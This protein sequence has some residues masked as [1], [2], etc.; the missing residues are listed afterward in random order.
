MFRAGT[1][2]ETLMPLSISVTI[3]IAVFDFRSHCKFNVLVFLPKHEN[4]QC[5]QKKY[6]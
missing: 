1:Q 4:M 3:F 6:S 5:N 2:T